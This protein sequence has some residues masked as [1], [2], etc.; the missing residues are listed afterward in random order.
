MREFCLGLLSCLGPPFPS[1]FSVVHV[2][3][4]GLDFFCVLVFVS[5]CRCAAPASASSSSS[6]SGP[7]PSLLTRHRQRSWLRTRTDVAQERGGKTDAKGKNTP[8]R[9]SASLRVWRKFFFVETFSSCCALSVPLLLLTLSPQ[10][11]SCSCVFVCVCSCKLAFR[12]SA[13]R[14]P[15]SLC[16][17]PSPD[18]HP[19]LSHLPRERGLACS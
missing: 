4:V 13:S 19:S 3:A 1:L 17:S 10:H 15:S 11:C 6:S 14:R 12:L 18:S 16:F 8:K 5:S 9:K 7:R 2:C